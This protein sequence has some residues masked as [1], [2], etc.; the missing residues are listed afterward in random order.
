M[1]R[2]EGD[3]RGIISGYI[4]VEICGGHLLQVCCAHFVSML[5]RACLK[6]FLIC[7]LQCSIGES[8][9]IKFRN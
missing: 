7:S 1:E 3:I 6:L 5:D 9:N 2:T 8:L 4:E